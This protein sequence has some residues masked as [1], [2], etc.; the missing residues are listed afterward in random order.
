MNVFHVTDSK[1]VLLLLLTVLLL[2]LHV[3]GGIEINWPVVYQRPEVLAGL[4]IDEEDRHHQVEAGSAEANS[5]HCRVADQHFAVTA[6]MRLVTHHVE[7]RHLP[8]QACVHVFCLSESSKR[9]TT[10]Q[11]LFLLCWPK[12][13]LFKPL[14]LDVITH[15]KKHFQL[16]MGHQG[17]R[18]LMTRPAKRS[19][20]EIHMNV[21]CDWVGAGSTGSL[22]D[23]AEPGVALAWQ[24][25]PR[26]LKEEKVRI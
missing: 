5:V 15:A 11:S 6:A 18:P 14:L 21:S 20:I 19:Y 7:E 1:C 2:L 25:K 16:V 10:E 3:I 4:H 17:L 13:F 23:W 26:W 9:P 22:K 12:M 24:S 8:K